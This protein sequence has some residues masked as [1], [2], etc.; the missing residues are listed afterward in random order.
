MCICPLLAFGNEVVIV[1]EHA[2]GKAVSKMSSS[3]MIVAVNCHKALYNN[4][5]AHPQVI[6]ACHLTI[7]YP[8]A[9]LKFNA[10]PD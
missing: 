5:T 2:K 10:K 6:Q 7:G 4:F 1:P 8:I 9:H 3:V